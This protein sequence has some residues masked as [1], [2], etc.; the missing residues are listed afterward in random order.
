MSIVKRFKHALTEFE[1]LPNELF[2]EMFGYLTCIETVWAFARL[3]NRFRNLTLEYCR[4]FDFKSISKTKLDYIT[5]QHDIRRWKSLRLSDD[6]DTPGQVTYF[7]QILSFA[8]NLSHLEALTVVNTQCTITNSLLSQ[9][10]SFQHL[11]SL[12]IGSICGKNLPCINLVSLKYLSINSCMHTIWFQKIS[13]DGLQHTFEHNCN[14]EHCLVYP[15]TLR[16]LKIFADRQGGTDIVRT[17]L[18]SLSKLTNLAIYDGAWENAVPDGRVWEELIKV[19]LPCLKEFN[20]CFKFWRDFTST[21]DIDSIIST[22]STPFYRQQKSWFVQCDT[23]YQ[24]FS[25][26]MLY[27]LPYA[28][29]H[30]EV[31]THS[32][33]NS[34]SN[35]NETSKMQS[36]KSVKT[37]V[38][39][40]K[41]ETMNERLLLRNIVNLHLTHRHIFVNWILKI[42]RLTQLTLGHQSLAT[43]Y[44]VLCS[45]TNRWKHK[46]IC[47]ILSRKIRSLKLT[48]SDCFSVNL[49]NYIK[50][51]Q[52]LNIIRVFSRHCEHLSI[53]VYSRNIVAGL[54]LR[55]MNQLRSLKVYVQEHGHNMHISKQ[56]LTDQNSDFHNLDYYLV[57]NGHEYSFWFGRR[58]L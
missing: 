25:V 23:H 39:D 40:A 24:Q 29:E 4:T 26:A 43:P 47:D 54:I 53:A 19:S 51:D 36:Y 41:C 5:Q 38:V 42:R 44:Q 58:Y 2:L 34:L 12:T 52:L 56:W 27:S 13:L 45:I 28:F 20:F 7:C 14:H 35:I 31:I 22:F 46:L 16:N 3:N 1:T 9:I 37:L 11:V 49:K 57:S 21:S 55:C 15:T 8:N 50:V 17:A 30:F 33:Q 10:T 48:S 32:S 18:K 6:D